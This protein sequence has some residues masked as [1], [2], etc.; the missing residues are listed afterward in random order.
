MRESN[1][2]A[3]DNIDKYINNDDDNN[4]KKKKYVEHLILKA[5]SN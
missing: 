5:R 3:D 1:Y 4:K 2:E